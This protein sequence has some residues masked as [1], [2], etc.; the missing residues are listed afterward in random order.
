[1]CFPVDG[2]L[3]F[4]MFITTVS[5]VNRHPFISLWTGVRVSLRYRSKNEIAG[6]TFWYTD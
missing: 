6:T 5:F 3:F 1:M 4:L 2:H